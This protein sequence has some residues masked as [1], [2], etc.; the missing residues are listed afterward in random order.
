MSWPCRVGRVGPDGTPGRPGCIYIGRAGKGVSRTEAIWGNPYPHDPQPC[1]A[2]A[3][4]LA[5]QDALLRR[6]GELEG[7]T[8]LCF[9]H[10]PDDADGPAPVCHG[11]ILQLAVA[12]RAR[13]VGVLPDHR[14][15]LA[16]LRDAARA[17]WP[18]WTKGRQA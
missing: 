17:R 4:Y 8:L 11:D 14:A 1:A 10:R 5:H 2:F 9:C 18:H 7:M 13:I 16:I 15:V 6:L 12:E 3:R